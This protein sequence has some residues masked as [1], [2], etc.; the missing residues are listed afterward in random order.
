MNSCDLLNEVHFVLDV[1]AM[2]GTRYTP[3]ALNVLDVHLQTLEDL[4][5]FCVGNFDSKQMRE[6][7]PS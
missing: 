3:T 7:P 1:E 6:S 5:D 2:A 4:N